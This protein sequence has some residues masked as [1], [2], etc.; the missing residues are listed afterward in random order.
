MIRRYRDLTVVTRY[1]VRWAAEGSPTIT[2]TFSDALTA[3]DR[4]KALIERT[5][6]SY[7]V[8]VHITESTWLSDENKR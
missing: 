3:T 4:V 1:E 5:N 2:E 7:L 6:V 8:L